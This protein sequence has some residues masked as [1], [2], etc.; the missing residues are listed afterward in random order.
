MAW[1]TT[2]ANFGLVAMSYSMLKRN[3]ASRMCSLWEAGTS[4]L[5]CQLSGITVGPLSDPS[6]VRSAEVSDTVCGSGQCLFVDERCDLKPQEAIRSHLHNIALTTM[7]PYLQGTPPN[8]CPE[9]V[10]HHG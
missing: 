6:L 2:A 7:I 1:L 10:W 3:G 8:A 4:S 9:K 5:G